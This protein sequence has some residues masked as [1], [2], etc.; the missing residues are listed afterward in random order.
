MFDYK[1]NLLQVKCNFE[2]VARLYE[3]YKSQLMNQYQITSASGK[4]TGDFRGAEDFMGPTM[5]IENRIE[6]RQ[7]KTQSKTQYRP[8][9]KVARK[10]TVRSDLRKSAHDIEGT[11]PVTS[12][13]FPEE[14]SNN[15]ILNFVV[16]PCAQPGK[17]MDTYDVKN[18]KRPAQEKIHSDESELVEPKKIAFLRN[19]DLTDITEEPGT[20][21][22]NTS[23]LDSHRTTQKTFLQYKAG[24]SFPQS[25]QFHSPRIV[26]DEI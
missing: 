4:R 14:P 17:Y 22:K 13:P 8:G 26:R 20:S 25:D 12:D 9:P 24:S 7:T 2:A 3:K 5:D 10:S 1:N 11:G 18:F 15:K 6:L 23:A 19:T 16:L 21:G